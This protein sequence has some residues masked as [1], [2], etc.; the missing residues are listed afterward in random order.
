MFRKGRSI[1]PNR[2]FKS[3]HLLTGSGR[4]VSAD[5]L[6]ERGSKLLLQLVQLLLIIYA[7]P[8]RTSDQARW[9]LHGETQTYEILM[10]PQGMMQ[11]VLCTLP[12]LTLRPSLSLPPPSPLGWCRVIWPDTWPST[13]TSGSQLWRQWDPTSQQPQNSTGACVDDLKEVVTSTMED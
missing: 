12:S 11:A 9:G 4:A 10:K 2:P 3:S 5:R 6:Q 7:Y 13:M 8:Y 1:F